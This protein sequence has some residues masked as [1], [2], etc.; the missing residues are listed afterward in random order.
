[1]NNVPAPWVTP[2]LKW[3]GGKR[4]LVQNIEDLFPTDFNRYIEPFLGGASIFFALQPEFALLSDANKDL[5]ATYRAIAKH[6]ERISSRLREYQ[7][8]HSKEFYYQVRSAVPTDEVERAVR[9]IYLNRTCYNG[10]YRVNLKG[11]FNVPIGTKQAVVMPTDDWEVVAAL[12]AGAQLEYSDFEAVIDRA[13]AGDF[14][15]ADPP[16][17]VKHNNNGFVKYNETI[18]A[19]ADQE[20]LCHALA[21]AKKRGATII[22]T[23]ADHESIWTLYGE[24]FEIQSVDRPSVIGGGIQYRGITSEVIIT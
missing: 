14:V 9:F 20:R 17:T 13:G 15:F 21:R 12:L 22:C 19:W 8:I 24:F 11:Q 7:R 5:I 4:W 2:F 6:P 16:Y 3:A 23:N 1:M 18:F 10:L